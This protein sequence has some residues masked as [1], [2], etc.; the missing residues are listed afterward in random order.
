MLMLEP[1]ITSAVSERVSGDYSVRVMLTL[2]AEG[3]DGYVISGWCQ[4]KDVLEDPHTYMYAKSHDVLRLLKASANM[5][6]LQVGA[7]S[8]KVTLWRDGELEKTYDTMN[9]E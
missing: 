5:V 3:K 1:E 7:T 9:I 6:S 4:Q 2:D 8:Y